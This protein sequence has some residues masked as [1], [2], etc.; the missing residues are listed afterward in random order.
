M[1]IFTVAVIVMI[2]MAVG[3]FYALNVLQIPA[4]VAFSTPGA[5]VD[6]VEAGS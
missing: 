4:D 2:G 3:G 6:P 1:R 5:R